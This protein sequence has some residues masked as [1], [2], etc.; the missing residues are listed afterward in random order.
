MHFKDGS[1]KQM[2]VS[3]DNTI[4]PNTIIVCNTT[5]LVPHVWKNN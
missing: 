4:L 3:G 1:R 5:I 2:T